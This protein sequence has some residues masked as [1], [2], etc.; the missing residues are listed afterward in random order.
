MLS[1]VMDAY[2][3][4][5][6]WLKWLFWLWLFCHFASF[7]ELFKLINVLLPRILYVTLEYIVANTYG[8]AIVYILGTPKGQLPV[9]EVE[10]KMM[11]ESMAI[12]RYVA[13]ETG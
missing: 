4:T 3:A 13:R 11:C 8:Y 1:H 12:A 2:H 9:L 10:G 7:Q 6:L 5:W